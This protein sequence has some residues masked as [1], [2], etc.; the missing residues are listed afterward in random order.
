MNRIW[1]L[2]AKV[3][4]RIF[5]LP[6]SLGHVHPRIVCRKEQ[7]K[8][9]LKQS[10]YFHPPLG[11]TTLLAVHLLFPENFSSAVHI[12]KEREPGTAKTSEERG[13]ERWRE[14]G[15]EGKREAW[16]GGRERKGA[17]A[18]VWRWRRRNRDR[19]RKGEEGRGGRR[20]GTRSRAAQGG[21]CTSNLCWAQSTHQARVSP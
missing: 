20:Q 3:R 15:G 6:S 2:E 8:S 19:G 13:E 12:V 4:I 17:G 21:W 7:C 14:G 18:S 16:A 11:W 9:N 5:L 1:M 10:G